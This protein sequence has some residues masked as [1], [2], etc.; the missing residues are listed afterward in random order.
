[1]IRHRQIN[2]WN[3]IKIPETKTYLDT[4]FMADQQRK[5][6]FKKINDVETIYM[7]LEF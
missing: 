5:E 6:C 7:K 1:M 4:W 3:G 2:V